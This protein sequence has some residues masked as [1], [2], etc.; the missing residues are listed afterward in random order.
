MVVPGRGTRKILREFQIIAA[1]RG[2]GSAAAAPGGWSVAVIADV[3]AARPGDTS[4]TP[5]SVE[6]IRHPLLLRARPTP[7]RGVVMLPPLAP[8]R[9]RPARL[10]S[11]RV[12]F[13][14][15]AG[16]GRG[17]HDTRAEEVAHE[18]VARGPVVAS[19][20]PEIRQRSEERRVGKECRSRWSPYH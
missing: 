1:R 8:L 15:A 18:P 10:R 20:D 9:G 19:V 16:G 12:R 17:R 6:S 11:P 13:E 3:H 2:H 14:I 4:S 5:R 7:A